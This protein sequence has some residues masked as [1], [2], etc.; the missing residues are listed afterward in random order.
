MRDGGETLHAAPDKVGAFFDKAAAGYVQ[1][2]EGLH[3]R[4]V[5]ADPAAANGFAPTRPAVDPLARSIAAWRA[6]TRE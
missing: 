2:I 1:A 5:L 4:A 3:K 6:P